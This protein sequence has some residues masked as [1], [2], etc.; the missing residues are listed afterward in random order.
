MA[1]TCADQIDAATRDG[2]RQEIAAYT[3]APLAEVAFV[4]TGLVNSAGARAPLSRLHTTAVGACCGIGNPDAF[5]RTLTALGAPPTPERFRTF[6]DHHPYSAADLSDLASWV[7]ARGIEALIVTQKDLVKLP[8]VHLGRAELW[9]LE[10]AVEFLSGE[11]VL[12]DRLR[13]LSNQRERDDRHLSGD[14]YQPGAAGDS[15]P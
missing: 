7:C 15:N 2:L 1:L 3:A 6:P 8:M 10:L 12:L 11:E 9:G 4:P 5:R 14:A 13:Q